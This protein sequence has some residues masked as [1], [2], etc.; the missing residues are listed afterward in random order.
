MTLRLYI[1]GQELK[2]FATPKGLQNAVNSWQTADTFTVTLRNRNPDGELLP[3]TTQA[4]SQT[5]WGGEQVVYVDYNTTTPVLSE[6]LFAGEVRVLSGTDPSDNL[7]GVT[8]I[9]CTTPINRL[10]HVME[11]VAFSPDPTT[12]YPNDTKRVRR[13]GVLAAPVLPG[14]DWTSGVSASLHAITY[15]TPP[16]GEPLTEYEFKTIEYILN[17]IATDPGQFADG[18]YPV[19]TRRWWVSAYLADVAHPETGVTFV[20]NYQVGYPSGFVQLKDVKS[21]PTDTALIYNSGATWRIDY[22]NVIRRVVIAGPRTEPTP[23]TWQHATNVSMGHGHITKVLGTDG[24]WDAG[25]VSKQRFTGGD[26]EA[27]AI[28]QEFYLGHHQF[29]QDDAPYIGKANTGQLTVNWYQ[30][31]IGNTMGTRAWNAAPRWPTGIALATWDCRAAT[32]ILREHFAANRQG[33]A[34]VFRLSDA[35]NYWRVENTGGDYALIKREGGSESTVGTCGRTPANG[36][37]VKVFT[38]G[39]QIQVYITAAGVPDGDYDLQVTGETFNQHETQHGLYVNCDSDPANSPQARFY[40]FQCTTFFSDDAFGIGT[41]TAVTSWTDMSYAI[42]KNNNGTLTCTEGGSTYETSDYSYNDKLR[43][44]TMA[45]FD[46]DTRSLQRMVV[47]EKLPS[48]ASEWVRLRTRTTGVVELSAAHPWYVQFAGKDLGATLNNI[49][50]RKQ[51]ANLFNADTAEYGDLPGDWPA[52]GIVQSDDLDTFVLRQNRADAIFRESALPRITFNCVVPP[53]AGGAPYLRG[54]GTAVTCHGA[55]WFNNPLGDNTRQFLTVTQIQRIET[56][57]HLTKPQYALQLDSNGQSADMAG[58]RHLLKGGGNTRTKPPDN[59]GAITQD[60]T[61]PTVFY[62]PDPTGD[63]NYG[64]SLEVQVARI[65]TSA[66]NANAAQPVGTLSPDA[67]G[68]QIPQGSL[69]PGGQ[70]VLRHRTTLRT[71]LASDWSESA[72][73]VAPSAAPYTRP[74][75]IEQYLGD[76][77]GAI[78][79]GVYDKVRVPE[80]GKIVGWAIGSGSLAGTAAPGTIAVDVQYASADAFRL[81][82]NAAFASIAGTDLPTLTTQENNDSIRLTGWTTAVKAG[83]WVRFKVQTSPTATAKKVTVSLLVLRGEPV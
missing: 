42:V 83:D 43:V 58:Q 51:Y 23:C 37:Q 45:T 53:L 81:T 62:W 82:G 31:L 63:E 33:M 26:W 59:R 38:L 76:G 28:V 77:V 5:Q 24:T 61:D 10:R 69:T 15:P 56:S 52:N 78:T 29:Q 21:S 11:Y 64:D 13:L 44:A 75:A 71:G 47:W 39:S 65:D 35:D 34:L 1:A 74:Y 27:T 70:Y 68:V 73:F 66:G 20:L 3:F 57:G 16:L 80:S 9:T 2:R 30:D 6:I 40:D 49:S 19:A 79:P 50:L 18:G 48:G 14:W 8:T 7:K 67:A 46:Y 41:V 22:S 54:Q 55:G 12:G 4:G 25:A 17:D 60:S 72:P 32:C 36:D